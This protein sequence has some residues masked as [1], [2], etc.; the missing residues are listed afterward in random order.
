MNYLC[1]F[2][3]PPVP[4]LCK[5]RLAQTIGPDC[6]SKL[7]QAM[8]QDICISILGVR[9]AVPQLWHPP[10]FTPD[11]YRESI[12]AGFSFYP[13]IG[14]DLGERMGYTF[15]FLLK[16]NPKNRVII[17]GGDCITPSSEF[18]DQVFIELEKVHVIIQPSMDGGYVLVGQSHRYSDIFS[19]LNWGTATV[20]RESLNLIHKKKIEF[21]KL[22]KTF[23]VDR[24]ND[25]VLLSDFT[26][27][28]ASPHVRSWMQL[29]WET[30]K[31][32]LPSQC[33]H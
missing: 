12:P 33:C 3:K 22:P 1:L 25:L 9:N 16:R 28:T 17:L 23:D 24:F 32:F 31:K 15:D 4:G 19:G 6:A 29:N 20:Y 21:K 5:S 2:T 18:L 14:D 7:A 13:Q 10:G 8:I 26:N 27:A 11:Q 30:L